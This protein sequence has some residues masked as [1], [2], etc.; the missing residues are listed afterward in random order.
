MHVVRAIQSCPWRDQIAAVL[1]GAC[2]GADRHGEVWA[3]GREIRL[4]LYPAKWELYGKSA[5]PIRNRKMAD[6]ADGLIAVWD[7]KSRGTA[8]MIREAQKR[9]LRVHIWRL[10]QHGAVRAGG[11]LRL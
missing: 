1:S 8:N 4:E 2:S 11:E 3:L 6:Q 9:G 10:D 7:G 5:G